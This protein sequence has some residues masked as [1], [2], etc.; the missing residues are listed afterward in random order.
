MRLNASDKLAANERASSV[1][2]V[3]GT[4]SSRTCP[5]HKRLTS[6]RSKVASCPTTTRCTS[7]RRRSP[8]ARTVFR[9]MGHLLSP[10]VNAPGGVDHAAGALAARLARL[11]HLALELGE[12]QGQAAPLGHPVEPAGGAGEVEAGRRVQRA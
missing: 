4:P 12:A 9:S 3:P 10:S 2:A 1:L 8:S 7:S 5:S 11:A 6:M